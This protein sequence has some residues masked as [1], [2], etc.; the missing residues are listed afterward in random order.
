MLKKTILITSMSSLLAIFIFNFVF[1][2][3]ISTANSTDVAIQ[4]EN[5]LLVSFFPFSSESERYTDMQPDLR[6]NFVL[7]MTLMEGEIDSRVFYICH[8]SGD[9]TIFWELPPA[10]TEWL[11]FIPTSGQ[12]EP[13][14][15]DPI[16]A[17]FNAE[18]LE[19]G[20]YSTVIQ[21]ISNSSNNPS[22]PVELTVLPWAEVEIKIRAF[23]PCGAVS[24]PFGTL[25]GGDN[26]S[27]S[28]S[29]GQSR[30]VE[31]VIVTTNPM[32]DDPIISRPATRYWESTRNYSSVNDGGQQEG[33]GNQDW[34]RQLIVNPSE[35]EVRPASIGP[36]DRPSFA[37]QLQSGEGVVTRFLMEGGN[38]FYGGIPPKLDADI[39]VFLRQ[40]S[41][42]EP[43][44]KIYGIHD[45]FPA[46]EIYLNQK[47]VYCHDPIATGNSA[48]S[49]YGWL[50]FGGT[51][52]D[53]GEWK[54]IEPINCQP[55]KGVQVNSPIGE[56]GSKI[57]VTG[58]GFLLPTSSNEYE[59][60][61]NMSQSVDIYINDVLLGTV[62]PDNFGR[63]QITLDTSQASYGFY[64]VSVI[65]S[66]TK[67]DFMSEFKIE[68]G[69][70]VVA[71]LNGIKTSFVVPPDIAIEPFTLFLPNV[72]R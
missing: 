27:F 20:V 53:S 72:Q 45:G 12:I 64:E 1:I 18:A 70:F 47:L 51:V 57:T 16:T 41:K 19:A 34:C 49:L 22:L 31:T 21:P 56:R 59:N 63:F 48:S 40:M 14:E 61:S 13:S 26:R 28:Y 17:T 2:P 68:T 36:V 3:P 58:N 29:G 42:G 66:I 11:S 10:E 67:E 44:Y 7:T 8:V 9:E 5:S 23:I 43:E 15:C 62:E 71:E 33:S 38:P 32:E 39:V 25:F 69:S 55:V 6:G 46:Y 24:D 4:S 52:A 30:F 37:G 50:G 65:D 35:P 54:S 60:L